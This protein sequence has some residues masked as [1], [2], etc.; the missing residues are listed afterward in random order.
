MIS[1]ADAAE[2]LGVHQASVSRMVR[3]GKLRGERIGKIW[4]VYKSS[5]EEY[6]RKFGD[7]PKFSPK[8]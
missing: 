4:V 6:L 8:R 5:V 7:L 2:I 3:E 1:T